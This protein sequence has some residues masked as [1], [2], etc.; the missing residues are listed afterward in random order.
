MCEIPFHSCR[1]FIV[2]FFTEIMKL[3]VSIIIYVAMMALQWVE[4]NGTP[5]PPNKGGKLPPL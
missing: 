1:P 2:S 5:T 3:S 4:G